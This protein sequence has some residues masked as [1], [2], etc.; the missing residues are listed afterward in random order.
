MEPWRVCIPVVADSLHFDKEQFPDPHQREK[1]GIRIRI[2]VMQIYNL[3][4][5]GIKEPVNAS[6]RR[7]MMS[8]PAYIY[9]RLSLYEVLLVCDLHIPYL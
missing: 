7:R 1:G 5:L 8:C 9:F 2:K 6:G 3:S 4:N